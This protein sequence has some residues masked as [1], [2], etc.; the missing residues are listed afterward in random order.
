MN[1]AYSS[2]NLFPSFASFK[3]FSDLTCFKAFE[4]FWA[5]LASAAR[6]YELVHDS[7]TS[8]CINSMCR[9]L[10]IPTV[11]HH[12]TLQGEEKYDKKDEKEKGTGDRFV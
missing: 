9:G 8:F 12:V 7:D 6:L 4:T 1:S 11:P 10:T 5:S 3:H 2:Y